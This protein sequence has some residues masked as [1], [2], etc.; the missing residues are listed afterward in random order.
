[1]SP[2]STSVTFALDLTPHGRMKLMGPAIK[3]HVQREV[4]AVTVLQEVLERGE[5]GG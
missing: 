4:G 2:T 5:R 1:M 3:R